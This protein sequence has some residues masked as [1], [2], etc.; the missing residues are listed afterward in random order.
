MLSSNMDAGIRHCLSFG[1]HDDARM[2][3]IF[4]LIFTRVLRQGARFDGTETVPTQPRQRKLCEV[5]TFIHVYLD[6][7]PYHVVI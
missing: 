1:Y 2:R 3:A 5:N 7:E 4:L 6:V